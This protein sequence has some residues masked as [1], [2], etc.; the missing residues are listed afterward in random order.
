MAGAQAANVYLNACEPWKTAKTDRDRTATT[1][2]TALQ[3]IA[4]LNVALA[5]FLPFSAAKLHGWLGLDATMA[6]AGWHRPEVAAGTVLGA[7]SPLYAKVELPD[8]DEDD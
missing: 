2:W 6:G 1:L 7:P 3:A 8:V 4:G 5:P